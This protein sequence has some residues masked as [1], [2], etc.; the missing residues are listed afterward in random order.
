MPTVHT[1]SKLSAPAHVVFEKYIQPALLARLSRPLL[2]LRYLS[3]PAEQWEKGSH[4]RI[5]MYLFGFIPL[6]EHEIRFSELDKDTLTF[7]TEEKGKSVQSWRH[8]YRVK[9]VSPTECVSESTITF[10]AGSANRRVGAFIRIL[11]PFRHFRLR[12]MFRKLSPST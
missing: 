8:E 2:S 9:A 3:K 1:S 12:R 7:V 11:Y 4:T 5:K 10:E 6:G